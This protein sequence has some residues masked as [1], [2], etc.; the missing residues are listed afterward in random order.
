VSIA[1]LT[2]DIVEETTDSALGSAP[3]SRRPGGPGHPRVLRALNAGLVL[4]AVGQ[5]VAAAVSLASGHV[6]LAVV[7]LATLPALLRLRR[8]LRRRLVCARG[9]WWPVPFAALATLGTLFVAALWVG[10][11]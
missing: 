4:T 7:A 8:E 6:V 2:Q 10:S 3:G 11:P 1:V 9:G 5:T